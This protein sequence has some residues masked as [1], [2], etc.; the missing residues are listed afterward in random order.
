MRAVRHT[1]DGPA[2][3]DVAEPDGPGIRVAM[4]ASGI[5]SSDLLGI[6]LGPEPITIGHEFSA[7]TPSGEIV[8]VLPNAPC[9]HCDQCVDGRDELCRVLLPSVHGFFRDGGM[10]DAV[11]VDPS[12]LVALPDGVDGRD[13]CLV[14]PLAV[15]LH[16]VHRLAPEPG[17][18]VLVIGAGAIGLC[19]IAVLRDLGLDTAVEARHDHQR[20]AAEA[21]GARAMGGGEYDAVIEAAGSQTALDSAVAR[22]RPGGS[23]ALAATYPGGVRLGV[24]LSLKEVS[25]VPAFTYGHHHGRRE[26]DDAAELL[27]RSPDLPGLVVTHRFPLEEASEAFRVAADRSSG[28]IKVVLEP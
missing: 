16:T 5:C 23:V 15:A 2:V 9:G 26:F 13:A 24:E 25:L 10:A 19:C 20:N 8:A 14:E 6:N 21:L 1:A 17:A 7:R 4:V 27:G 28:A 18:R 11:L 12:S 22:V 3:V